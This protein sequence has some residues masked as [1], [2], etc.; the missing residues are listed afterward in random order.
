MRSRLRQY[1]GLIWLVA[2][3]L[4]A[5]LLPTG[6]NLPQTGPATLAEYAPVPGEQ[7]GSA[8]LGRLDGASS[9][10][11]G[12]GGG[13]GGA[14]TTTTE[15]PSKAPGGRLIRKAGTK[16]CVGQPPRQTEDP[17]SPACVAFFEGDNG[18][19]T[20]RGVTGS[21]IRI[22]VYGFRATNT[23]PAGLHDWNTER[24]SSDSI[25][26]AT[27]KALTR[28]FADRY[29]TYG[30]S[31][32]VW[33]Y[34]STATEGSGWTADM[35]RIREQVDP[36]AVVTAV[37][38]TAPVALAAARQEML[39]VAYAAF[40]RADYQQF[41]PRLI[42]WNPDIE[43]Q[44]AMAARYICVR[45][46]GRVARWSKD[47]DLATRQRRFRIAFTDD[48][49][50]PLLEPF[51]IAVR[52]NLQ[53]CGVEMDGDVAL[54]SGA[55][56]HAA[57]VSAMRAAG[58]TTVL[59]ATSGGSSAVLSQAASAQAWFPEFVTL[60]GGAVD[61]GN[62]R[63]P[64][65]RTHASATWD[66]AFG[67]TFDYRRGAIEDQPWF[68]AVREGCSACAE[69]RDVSIVRLYDA[70]ALLMYGIQ[71]AGPRL[72]LASID[73]GMHALQQVRSNDPFR[74]AAYFAPGNYSFVKDAAEIWWDPVGA[75]PSSA[76][77]GCYRLVDGG[78]RSRSVDWA[79]DDSRLFDPAASACQGDEYRPQ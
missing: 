76:A 59:L 15:E 52:R 55:Q 28:Y 21:E 74:P 42:S 20:T 18:G 12:A 2:A 8:D 41:A 75:A 35:A 10:G 26:D 32:R 14:T 63:N 47:P 53:D 72:T 30:R 64:S 48:P 34:Y 57:A 62:D 56:N 65:G 19:A 45:L 79:G 73:R 9:K 11:V 60:G 37:D 70:W 39:A 58:V 23:A 78:L 43:D 13:S 71:A 22:V 61:R 5:L 69:P 17:L 33:G 27:G 46:S 1:P 31:L 6:L 77:P 44:A 36:L 50:L 24:T 7:S 40:S 49:T 16:R 51:R 4:L 3:G 66:R 67:I 29:Q 38:G 25:T 68:R 54:P